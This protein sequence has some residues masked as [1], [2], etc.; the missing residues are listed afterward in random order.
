MKKF[1]KSAQRLGLTLEMLFRAVDKKRNNFILLD[2]FRIFVSKL[3][4]NLNADEINKL[5]QIFDDDCTETLKKESY[6]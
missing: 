3:K 2:E 4:L 6:F 1:F 5:V